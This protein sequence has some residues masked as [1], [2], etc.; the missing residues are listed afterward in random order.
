MNI[1][2]SFITNHTI[3]RARM[4]RQWRYERW[5]VLRIVGWMGAHCCR[6][7]SPR[8]ARSRGWLAITWNA[9]PECFAPLHKRLKRTELY[10]RAI[11]K[12]SIIG[13]LF[14]KWYLL[15]LIYTNLCL[16]WFEN[17]MFRFYRM[18]RFFSFIKVE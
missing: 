13:C 1:V 2:Y 8:G 5:E 14:W 16:N 9:A 6:G 12:N 7:L 3:N 4:V 18:Y 15:V 11:P 17:L 10:C